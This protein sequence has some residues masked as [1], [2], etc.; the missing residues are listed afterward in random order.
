MKKG[1]SFLLV[2]LV[3]LLSACSSNL[4]KLNYEVLEDTVN[5]YNVVHITVDENNSVFCKAFSTVYIDVDENTQITFTYG[6]MGDGYFLEIDGEYLSFDKAVEFDYI[7]ALDVKN[8]GYGRVIYLDSIVNRLD[9]NLDNFTITETVVHEVNGEISLSGSGEWDTSYN[10]ELDL[11]DIAQYLQ[12]LVAV[13]IEEADI[14]ES[15]MCVLL[16]GQAPIQLDLNSSTYSLNIQ[17]YEDYVDLFFTEG[18]NMYYIYSISDDDSNAEQL[19]EY[20]SN[21]HEET[22]K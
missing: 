11:V 21:L 13:R 18:D 20:L 1:M 6:C 5:G 4:I 22:N 10:L 15:T 7:S 17:V 2:V 16:K 8:S 14:C 3:F 12:P 9:F 19:F